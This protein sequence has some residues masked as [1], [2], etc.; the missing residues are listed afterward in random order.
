MEDNTWTPPISPGKKALPEEVGLWL[1][2]RAC[3]TVATVEPDGRPQLSVVWAHCTAQ[4]V[5]FATVRGRRKYDNIVR[6]P[7]VTVLISPP[8]DQDHYVEIRGTAQIEGDGRELIDLLHERY[9]GTRPYPWDGPDDERVVV[10]VVPDRI[11]VF[12]G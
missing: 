2:A 3:P 6:N 10:R 5:L 11:L 7:H 9:R 12:H 4:D 8:D 1:E